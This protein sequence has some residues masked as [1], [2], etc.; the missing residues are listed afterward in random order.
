[1]TN[2]EIKKITISAQNEVNQFINDFVDK[3]NNGT[4]DPQNFMLFTEMEKQYADL[5]NHTSQTYSNLFS[6][7]LS[8]F[9]EKDLIK[10]KKENTQTR[11]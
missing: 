4:F 10:L 2:D 6:K 3:L 7:Y 5:T 1:M 9:D 8:Q 11:G